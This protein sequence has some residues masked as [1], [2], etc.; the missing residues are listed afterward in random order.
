MAAGGSGGGGPLTWEGGGGGMPGLP[1]PVEGAAPRGGKSDAG[2]G[3][4]ARR[5]EPGGGAC[6]CIMEARLGGK[7]ARFLRTLRRK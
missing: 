2:S 3:S 5:G 7:F 4:G 6:A 1:G